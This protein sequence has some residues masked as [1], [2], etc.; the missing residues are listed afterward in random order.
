LEKQMPAHFGRSA[1]G[2]HN[3]D[4]DPNSLQYGHFLSPIAK[5]EGN[6]PILS[7]KSFR[8]D[9]LGAPTGRQPMPGPALQADMS[10][11]LFGNC[12]AVAHHWAGDRSSS[13]AH[14]HAHLLDHSDDREFRGDQAAK[15]KLP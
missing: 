2:D 11:L 1:H 10:F 8:S 5:F 14:Q 4:Q 6:L 7:C 9:L 13:A 12:F 3:G 15:G